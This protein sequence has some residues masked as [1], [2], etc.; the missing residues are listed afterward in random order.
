MNNAGKDIG[1]IKYTN[2]LSGR[3]IRKNDI[4]YVH[5][6]GLRKGMALVLD[7]DKDLSYIVYI[8]SKAAQAVPNP[9]WIFSNVLELYGEQHEHHR[10]LSRHAKPS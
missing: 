7:T 9:F 8:D 4:V 1:D 5:F 3:P 2:I 10:S 6:T